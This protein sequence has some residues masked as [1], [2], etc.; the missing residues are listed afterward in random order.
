MKTCPGKNLEIKPHM[1][2][3][4]GIFF[5]A[6]IRMYFITVTNRDEGQTLGVGEIHRELQT[7]TRLTF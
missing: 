1:S 5:I 6:E 7:D 4:M 3:C 2:V